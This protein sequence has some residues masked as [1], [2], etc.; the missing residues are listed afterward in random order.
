MSKKTL[1]FI[2]IKPTDK[3]ERDYNDIFILKDN[4]IKN[5]F[6]LKIYVI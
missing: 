2:L 5:L 3:K 1:D 4:K 6:V